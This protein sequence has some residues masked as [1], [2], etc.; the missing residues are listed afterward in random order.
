M[1]MRSLLAC[2]LLA[3]ALM[4]RPISAV[5]ETATVWGIGN[6]SC[7]AAE[8]LSRGIEADAWVLG[9][10]SSA[11]IVNAQ[12]HNVGSGTDA[13]GIWGE[14]KLE[15]GANPSELFV[16]ATGKVYEKLE[17]EGR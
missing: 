12:D 14:V 16:A 13:L 8:S 7:A 2:C 9:Y 3:G 4:T 10:F 17:Q 5:A 1:E 6:D 15:C 11:N